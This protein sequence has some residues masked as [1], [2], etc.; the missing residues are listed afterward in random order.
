MRYEGSIRELFY[1]DAQLI[2]PSYLKDDRKI[3]QPW[4]TLIPDIS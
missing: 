4:I 3:E 1:R 2:G